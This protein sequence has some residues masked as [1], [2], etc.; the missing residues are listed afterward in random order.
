MEL[1]AHVPSPNTTDIQRI[2]LLEQ[3]G[4]SRNQILGLL[5]VRTLYRGGA[6]EENDPER[7]RLEFARWLYRQGR[8]ES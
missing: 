6:Y 8:L 4:L 3:E 2:A 7:K 1:Q 5:N